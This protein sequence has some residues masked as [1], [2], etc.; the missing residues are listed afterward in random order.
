MC[1]PISPDQYFISNHEHGV[2]I[3]RVCE[4]DVRPNRIVRHLTNP[5]GV[6]RTTQS[7]A[8]QVL[9]I[10][11]YDVGPHAGGTSHSRVDRVP[12]WIKVYYMR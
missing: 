4:Y 1:E 12:G 6:H 5:K 11:E 8:Q 9:D 3:C 10:I 7:V 2:A